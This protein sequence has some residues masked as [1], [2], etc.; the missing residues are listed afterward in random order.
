[1]RPSL[2]AARVASTK[3]MT[4]TLVQASAPIF[5]LSAASSDSCFHE[6]SVSVVAAPRSYAH[7]R[8]NT[9]RYDLW[10]SSGV[11]QSG[12]CEPSRPFPKADNGALPET[13][14]VSASAWRS[15]H[16]CGNPVTRTSCNNRHDLRH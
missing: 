9:L 5:K 4:I 11:P 15:R 3:G 12:G 10:V 7:L 14:R 2:S 1:M 13:G 16:M 8:R 6:L